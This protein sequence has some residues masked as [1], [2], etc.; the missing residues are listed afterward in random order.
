MTGIQYAESRLQSEARVA[1]RRD[2]EEMGSYSTDNWKNAT[3]RMT[4]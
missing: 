4:S 2:L 1:D 3:S